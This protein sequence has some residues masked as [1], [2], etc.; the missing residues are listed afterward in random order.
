M[1]CFFVM[2]LSTPRFSHE[3]TSE[4]SE[5]PPIIAK[6]STMSVAKGSL[7][8]ELHCDRKNRTEVDGW[9]AW[10]NM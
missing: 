5:T 1:D 8:S 7:V 6:T 2:S 4:T 3:L 10:E 9:E